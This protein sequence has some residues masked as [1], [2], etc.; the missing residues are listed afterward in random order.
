[1]NSVM[2]NEKRCYLCGSEIGLEKHHIMSGV[3]NRP[4]SEK[5]GLWVW[6]CHNCHTGTDGA[7]YDPEKNRM[8]KAEAQAAFEAEYGHQKWMQTF[9]K[10]YL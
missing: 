6:L 7:Q 1:M 8:L 3:A 4:L 9:R 5:Y 10:N 2:Q